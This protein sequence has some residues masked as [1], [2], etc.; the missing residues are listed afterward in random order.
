MIVVAHLA[1]VPVARLS[2]LRPHHL[3][4]RHTPSLPDRIACCRSPPAGACARGVGTH[5]G[6]R[7]GQLSGRGVSG[8]AAVLRAPA[9]PFLAHPGGALAAGRAAATRRLRIVLRRN[10]ADAKVNAPCM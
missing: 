8:R 5:C 10:F 2:L 6:S 9:E 7:A 1:M 4:G 3:H